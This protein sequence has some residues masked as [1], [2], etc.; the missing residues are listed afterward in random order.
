MTNWNRGTKGNRSEIEKE[1]QDVC[2][3]KERKRAKILYG[4]WLMFM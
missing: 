3:K 4:G 1:I 2:Q